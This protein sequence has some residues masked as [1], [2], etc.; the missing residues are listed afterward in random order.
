MQPRKIEHLGVAVR[1]LEE[2]ERLYAGVLGMP[3]VA[4]ETLEAMKLKV[5]KVA[6][7]ESVLEL[8]EPLPGE[9]VISKFLAGHGPGIHHVC[10]EV[11]DVAAATAE[12]K[13]KGLAPVWDQP[14]LGAGHRLVNFLRPKECGG[15]LIELNQPAEAPG[16]RK[17]L[18]RV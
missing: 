8:L 11:D 12:L 17:D 1:N 13:A 3:V 4:R 7:G 10:F 14:R 16:P 18:N 9:D 5:V 6:V 2:A 15:V